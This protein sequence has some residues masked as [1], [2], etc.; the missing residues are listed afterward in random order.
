ME[1]LKKINSIILNMEKIS[2][3]LLSVFLVSTQLLN[4]ISR[5]FFQI[6]LINIM[7]LAPSIVIWLALLGSTLAW[8]SQKHIRIEILLRYLPE[9]LIPF[10]KL[11]TSALA[12]FT[13]SLLFYTSFNYIIYEFKS[14][15]LK[16]CLLVIYPI[17]F[18]IL[19]FRVI[20]HA[21]HDLTNSR[22][23]NQK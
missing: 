19:I 11:T 21:S 12:L 2:V 18:G 1:G 6:S 15:D 20:L 7:E 4:I 23:N 14:F 16:S 5:N 3:C 10:A 17:F 13:F 9:K 8:E 22:Y